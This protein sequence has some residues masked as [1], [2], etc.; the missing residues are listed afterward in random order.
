[1]ISVTPH[2]LFETV[3]GNAASQARSRQALAA[4]LGEEQLGFDLQGLAKGYAH[5]GAS[6]KPVLI[7]FAA[8][9]DFVQVPTQG[10]TNEHGMFWHVQGHSQGNRRFLPLGDMVTPYLTGP[11]RV[12]AMLLAR[13][14]AYPHALAHPIGFERIAEDFGTHDDAGPGLP[15]YRLIPP[16]GYSALGVAFKPGAPSDYWCVAN[17]FI[18][19]VEDQA[20]MWAAV[21]Q[22]WPANGGL[23]KAA[24]GAGDRLPMGETMYILPN[25]PLPVRHP[26]AARRAALKVSKLRLEMTA[27]E[28]GKPE[29][30][31]STSRGAQWSPGVSSVFVLPCTAIDGR[32][33]ANQAVETPF[34]FVISRPVWKCILTMTS[35]SPGTFQLSRTMGVAATSASEFRRS[36]SLM[37]SPFGMVSIAN[38]SASVCA[39]FTQECEL[40]TSASM[41][42]SETTGLPVSVDLPMTPHSQYW[43]LFQRLE[44]C[45]G[46]GAVVSSIDFGRDQLLSL[47]A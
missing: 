2:Q 17:E 45:Q 38:G 37:V 41:S 12:P 44:V 5:N 16:A 28:L 23:V 14:P 26:E 47:P 31:N 36:T 22:G 25:T 43:Q 34:Y 8:A 19:D 40:M 7:K 32:K 9:S 6:F 13:D 39:S 20:P 4:T 3:G 11:K 15:L 10:Q 30:S 29:F 42:R 21:P 24:F 46:S 18:E 27:P 33:L 35:A 1:M